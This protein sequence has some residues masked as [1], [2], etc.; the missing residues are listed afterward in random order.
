MCVVLLHSCSQGKVQDSFLLYFLDYCGSVMRDLM[1][2]L[3]CSPQNNLIY[4]RKGEILGL[5][6]GKGV[7]NFSLIFHLSLLCLLFFLKLSLFFLVLC[8]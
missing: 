4:S 8:N 2:F 7:E 5:F 6:F 3:N 1:S